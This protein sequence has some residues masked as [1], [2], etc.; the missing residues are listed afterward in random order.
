MKYTE[1][2]QKYELPAPRSLIDE[3]DA[4]G[5]ERG[6]ATRQ[7]DAYFNAPHK[8]FLAPDVVS[9]WLRVRIEDDGRASLN[10]KRWLP[11][12]ATVKTHCDEYETSIADP[13][14]VR[15]TL[16]ALDFTE[17]ITVDKTRRE[18][19]TD[20][21]AIGIDTVAG[22]GSYVEFEFKG[23]AD[24]VEEA[25]RHIDTFIEGLKSTLGDRVHRG[26]P[27]ILLGRQH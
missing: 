21:L 2:E 9:D 25:T 22:A 5:A 20:D 19:T 18:W 7:I 17:L 11:L 8:D 23:E 16:A 4:L 26:Y 27:H 3:L 10:F 24:S 14:A 15:R 12:D 13:E 6:R 1:V